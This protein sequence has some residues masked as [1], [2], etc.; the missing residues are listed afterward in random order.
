MHVWKS[1]VINNNQMN[2]KLKQFGGMFAGYCISGFPVA[3]RCHTTPLQTPLSSKQLTLKIPNWQGL[4]KGWGQQCKK[5]SGRHQSF[6]HLGVKER[7]ITVSLS[8]AC[9]SQWEASES[10][11]YRNILTQKQNTMRQ[12]GKPTHQKPKSK[13]LWD[14]NI[15]GKVSDTLRLEISS[16]F[17]LLGF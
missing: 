1:P 4:D 3:R 15:N 11:L 2:L 7:K 14:R 10:G 13:V 17:L 5:H 12:Q 16:G 9:S 8:S 6:R